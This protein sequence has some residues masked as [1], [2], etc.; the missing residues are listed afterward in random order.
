MAFTAG[1]SSCG[2]VALTVWAVGDQR[3]CV[4][5]V[6]RIEF[7]PGPARRV[8]GFI[9][10]RVLR[11]D[12]F[13]EL[14]LPPVPVQDVPQFPLKDVVPSFDVGSVEPGCQLFS[15]SSCVQRA[16]RD[17]HSV[18]TSR[19]GHDPRRLRAV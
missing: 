18:A 7:V 16:G 8:R 15:A 13:D 1:C 6:E 10:W 17:L 12:R 4:E 2:N 11:D 19:A 9:R 5:C 3:R 14:R